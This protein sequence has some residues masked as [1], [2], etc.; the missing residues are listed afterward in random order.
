MKRLKKILFWLHLI[1]GVAGGLVIAMLAFTGAAMAFE[2]EILSLVDPK[3]R[4]VTPVADLPRLPA[5][6]FLARAKA[7]KPD[8][9]PGGLVLSSDPTVPVLVQVAG[10]H[11]LSL[12]PQTGEIVGERTPSN[13]FT[14]MLLL[15]LRLS[16]GEVGNW[17]VTVSNVCFLLLCLTGLYLWWPKTWNTVRNVTRFNFKLRG[18]AF[19]WNLHNVAGFWALAVLLVIT[20]TGLIMSYQWA[21]DLVYT[22]T[23]SA[24][25]QPA[26]VV[27]LDE[28]A[29][30]FPVDQAVAA[31][32]AR[33]ADWDTI[34]VITPSARSGAYRLIIREKGAAHTGMRS[35]LWL[36]GGTGEELRWEFYADSSLGRKLR[37]AVV[38]LHM[39][40]IAGLP[41]RVVAFAA[42]IAALTLVVTGYVLTWKRFAA[43]RARRVAA[44]AKFREGV[45]DAPESRGLPAP[46]HASAAAVASSANPTLVRSSP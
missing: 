3:A 22:L 31:A 23:G 38:P 8:K 36:H 40:T 10:A 2:P 25:P 28:K 19:H 46:A 5:S 41:G 26:P 9:K 43:W 33:V 18:K 15:H 4:A 39:G 30:R 24:K 29:P 11:A 12:H 37:A 20:T 7:A 13:F 17:I 14:V 34:A 1:L 32:T 45:P 35:T 42:C 27:K 16:S 21:S 44:R 6:E